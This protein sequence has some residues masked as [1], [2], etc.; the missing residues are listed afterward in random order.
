MLQS[1]ITFSHA[2]RGPLHTLQA[3]TAQDALNVMRLA[4][5]VVLEGDGDAEDV[6]DSPASNPSVAPEQE[7]EEE[8]EDVVVDSPDVA[9]AAE[10]VVCMQHVGSACTSCAKRTLL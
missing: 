1:C 2:H 3:R 7:E 9:S 8:E 5:H 4:L 10:G 6:T